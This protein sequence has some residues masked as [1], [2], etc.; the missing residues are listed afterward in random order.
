MNFSRL[1]RPDWTAFKDAGLFYGLRLA[2]VLIALLVLA[3]MIQ[4]GRAAYTAY[5][6]PDANL[7]LRQLGLSAPLAAGLTILLDLLAGVAS[8]GLSLLLFVRLLDRRKPH[9]PMALF[10]AYMLLTFS[11]VLNATISF[12]P[13]NSDWDILTSLVGFLGAILFVLFML[14]FPDGRYVPRGSVW[15]SRLFLAWFATWFFLPQLSPANLSDTTI[16]LIVITWMI[17][18]FAMQVYRYSRAANRVERQQ[19]K[20]VAYSLLVLMSFETLAALIGFRFPDWRP[21]AANPA[22]ELVVQVLSNMIWLIFPAAIVIA[23][24]RYRLWEVDTLINQTLV[25]ASLTLVLLGV[26]FAGVIVLQSVFLS[27]SGQSSGLAAVLSTLAVA[28]LFA[29]LRSRLQAVINRRFYRSRYDAERILS[30]FSEAAR[31]EVELNRL[32]ER[33]AQVVDQ[34]L[35]PEYVSLWLVGSGPRSKQDEAAWRMLL[36]VDDEIPP[37]DR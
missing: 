6:L 2:W 10:T 1:R 12:L 26:Y 28:G 3:I 17:S 16:S 4:S 27:M 11:L 32:G 23:I 15:L 20:W 19:I 7:P 8:L 25:Y 30:Q 33:L 35:Q 5:Q 36:E 29:P 18:A 37:G 21:F 9:E 31:S 22:G 24:L 14:I 34:T 13:E